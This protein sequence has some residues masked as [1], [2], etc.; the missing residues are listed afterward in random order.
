[1]GLALALGNEQA[2]RQCD[3]GLIWIYGLAMAAGLI[4]ATLVSLGQ[5]DLHA[6][7]AGL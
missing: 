2:L 7:I 5:S 4:H 3:V 1:M 6:E